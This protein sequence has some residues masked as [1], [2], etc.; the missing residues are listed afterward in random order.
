MTLYISEKIQ[1]LLQYILTFEI[2]AKPL[3]PYL[4]LNLEVLPSDIFKCF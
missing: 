4:D 3:I 1:Q 2:L